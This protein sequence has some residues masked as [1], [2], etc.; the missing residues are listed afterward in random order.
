[1]SANYVESISSNVPFADGK[2]DDGGVVSGEEV[3]VA[4]LEFPEF[5]LGEL[6]EP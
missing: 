6:S 3:L 5:L 4:W 2:G 1:M